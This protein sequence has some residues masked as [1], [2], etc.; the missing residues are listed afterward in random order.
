MTFGRTCA[1][2]DGY[3]TVTLGMLAGLPHNDPTTK[4]RWNLIFAKHPTSGRLRPSS[5]LLCLTS[6][7]VFLAVIPGRCWPRW[8]P[9]ISSGRSGS[10][11]WTAASTGQTFLSP[12]GQGSFTFTWS[13]GQVG[14]KLAHSISCFILMLYIYSFQFS[15]FVFFP[16]P[17]TRIS[18]V[19]TGIFWKAMNH[20][21]GNSQIWS[22]RRTFGQHEQVTHQRWSLNFVEI[23]LILNI[24]QGTKEKEICDILS[25]GQCPV[26]KA[27]DAV[28][29]VLQQCRQLN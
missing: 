24:H 17:R 21:H 25:Q 13:R 22:W 19:K 8:A 11:T 5:H 18:M 23:F 12:K 29:S 4:P 1:C 10:S 16:W 7:F 20:K 6:Q 14:A 15:V 28:C 2:V 9:A 27:S 3:L 26:L